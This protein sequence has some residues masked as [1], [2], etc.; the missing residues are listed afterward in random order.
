[1]V[2]E[3]RMAGSGTTLPV[4]TST[5]MGGT[6]TL[7][8]V[9]PDTSSGESSRVTIL[10]KF[11]DTETT[12]QGVMANPGAIMQVDSAGDL[13]IVTGGTDAN[14]F[15]VTAV[16]SESGRL[17]H[18]PTSP[19]NNTAGHSTWPSGGYEAGSR[20][21]K[22]DLVTYYAESSDSVPPR[23]T[24]QIGN[25][26]SR[27]MADYIEI[28]ELRYELQD[29]TIVTMPADLSLIRR[30]SVSI[31][32]SSEENPGRHDQGIFIPRY[33]GSHA[34][35]PGFIDGEVDASCS[36]DSIA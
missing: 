5:E 2:T 26:E 29:H 31:E 3:I 19:Y 7:Y 14:L 18:S 30:V 12:L 6:V 15:E 32:A 4:V 25:K 10:G 1:M 22:A 27:I 33:S 28:L 23:V 24:R 9:N 21:F 35:C 13:V 34:D 36:G 11:S 16:L 17:A 20:V 8:P